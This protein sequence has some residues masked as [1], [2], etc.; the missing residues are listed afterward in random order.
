MG[1]RW[2]GKSFLTLDFDKSLAAVVGAVGNVGNALFAFSK[3]IGNRVL[4]FRISYFRHFHSPHA[5]AVA[6]KPRKS[7]PLACCIRWAASVSLRAAA[8][9]FKI[10][11]LMPS[12]RY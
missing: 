11:R 12:L 5:V 9:R 4:V 6:R 7:L 1:R 10:A 2:R 8:M 3:E